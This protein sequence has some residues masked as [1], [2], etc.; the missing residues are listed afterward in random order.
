VSLASVPETVDEPLSVTVEVAESD[1]S[2]LETPEPRGARRLLTTLPD[3]VADAVSLATVPETD[4]D[5]LSVAAAV[6]VGESVASRLETPEPRG[7]RR[8]LTTL[9]D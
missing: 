7:A 6:A 1:A 8:L 2:R 4:D 5:A 9:P 3:W